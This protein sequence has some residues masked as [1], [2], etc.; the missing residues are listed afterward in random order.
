MTP[1]LAT[2]LFHRLGKQLV[3]RSGITDRLDSTLDAGHRPTRSCPH[4]P[5]GK[6]TLLSDWLAELDQRQGNRVGWL[7]LDDGDNDLT[8]FWSPWWR[9]CRL[10]ISMSTRSVASRCPPRRRPRP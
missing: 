6:T 7:S 10:P 3:A 8:R 1:V 9:P 4:R 5:A 2:K